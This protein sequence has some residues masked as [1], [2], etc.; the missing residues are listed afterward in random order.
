MDN[1]GKNKNINKEL[2]KIKKYQKKVETHIDDEIINAGVENLLKKVDKK[3][4]IMRL[5]TIANFKSLIQ[6]MID[7]TSKMGERD[8]YS[9][10]LMIPKELLD[11]G[12]KV[13]Y[14]YVIKIISDMYKNLYNLTEKEIKELID[15]Y[16][17]D[18]LLYNA[19]VILKKEK[20]DFNN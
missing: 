5:D 19:N 14:E 11:T 10:E 13:T 6:T 20:D 18:N 7:E 17:M 2:G 12:L 1:K 8:E 9:G 3:S 4:F 15:D 16:N